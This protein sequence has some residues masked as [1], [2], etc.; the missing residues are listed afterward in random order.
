ME[1]SSLFKSP[2][3]PGVILIKRLIAKGGDTIAG[4]HGAV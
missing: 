1:R 4:I 2:E 3:T